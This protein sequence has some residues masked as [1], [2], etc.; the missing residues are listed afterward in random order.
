MLA[1]KWLNI[2]VHLIGYKKTPLNAYSNQRKPKKSLCKDPRG[3]L[4]GQG[5][6][7][8]PATRGLGTQLWQHQQPRTFPPEAACGSPHFPP[9][10]GYILL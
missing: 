1:F 8:L 3:P 5:Q 4:Q 7:M 6:E 2:L 10:I 9:W